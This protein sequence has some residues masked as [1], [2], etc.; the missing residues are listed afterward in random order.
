MGGLERLVKRNDY[1]LFITSVDI[2]SYFGINIMYS[3]ITL[4]FF[5]ISGLNACSISDQTY[6]NHT[7]KIINVEPTNVD[8][9]HFVGGSVKIINGC[10]FT[11]RNMTIIPPGNGVYWWGIPSSNDTDVLPRVVGTALGSYNGQIITFNLDPQ[12]SFSQISIMEIRSEGDNRAYGAWSIT[13]NVRDYYNV[14][15]IPELD[16]D[17]ENWSSSSMT[18]AQR[19]LFF[20]IV[21]ALASVAFI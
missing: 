13:G 8:L 10:S 12:Y 18:T 17:P 20:Y 4:F 2:E 1:Q 7:A 9:K 3:Y 6:V 15:R 14:G 11:V 16:S 5:L 19:S 21:L